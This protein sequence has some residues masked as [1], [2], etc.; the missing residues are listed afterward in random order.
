MPDLKDKPAGSARKY[1]AG[2]SLGW[3]MAVG[4]AVFTLIG[5]I[6]DQ[7]IGSDQFW[8]LIGIFMGLFYCGYE[9]WKLVRNTNTKD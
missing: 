3:N 6:I 8:T 2:V 1:A 5:Y 9:V 7:K 4:M